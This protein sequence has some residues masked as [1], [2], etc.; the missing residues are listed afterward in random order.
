MWLWSLCLGCSLLTLG[1]GYVAHRR[2]QRQQPSMPSLNFEIDTSRKYHTNRIPLSVCHLVD[3]G[4][5]ADAFPI[6]EQI[7]Q[8]N[9]EEDPE[10]GFSSFKRDE[11]ARL[12]FARDFLLRCCSG[13]DEQA[14]GC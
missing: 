5:I 2:K 3:S 1:L 8:A 6:I 10:G 9:C 12:V 14:T 11:V 13:Q 7:H 4:D